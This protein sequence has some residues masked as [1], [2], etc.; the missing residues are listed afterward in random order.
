M[1][2]TSSGRLEFTRC[3]VRLCSH[4]EGVYCLYAISIYLRILAFNTISIFY[5]V[6][7]G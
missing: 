1:M 6:R 7:V 2:D 5:D 3:S 4:L